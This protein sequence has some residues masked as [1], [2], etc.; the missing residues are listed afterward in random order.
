MLLTVGM[1]CVSGSTMVAYALILKG[2]MA[3]VA[4]H[5]LAA[6]LISAPAGV[7]LSRIVVPPA[8]READEPFNDGELKHYAGSIDAL[9]TGTSDGLTIVLNVG[10]TLIVVV[11]LLAMADQ[12]LAL[13]PAVGGAAPSIERGLGFVFAPLA[14]ALGLNWSEAP[15]AGEL[16]G[17]KLVATEF[18]AFAKLAAMGP[19][20]ISPRGRMIMTYALCGFANLAS[21]GINVAGFSVLAPARRAEVISLVWKALAAGFLATCMTASVVGALPAALF[22]G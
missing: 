15:A 18:S 10:A 11:A 13:L 21:V 7:L 3:N 16:L 4:A 8:A 1:S 12:L 14:W 5:V 2:T 9:I 17:I 20:A 6:S 19:H 22:D